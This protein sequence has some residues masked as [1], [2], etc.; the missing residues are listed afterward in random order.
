VLIWQ[1][2]GQG[3][4]NWSAVSAPNSW[5][6]ERQSRSFEGIS[7]FD[8]GRGCNLSPTGTKQQAEQ[9]SGLRVSAGFFSV[10]GVKPSLGRTFVAEEETLG[11]NHEVILSYGLWKRR[12]GGD[13]GFGG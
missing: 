4:D 9:V 2:S 6:F 3:H 7:I 8:A 5:D 1:T 12:Y 13:P 11:K 10:L